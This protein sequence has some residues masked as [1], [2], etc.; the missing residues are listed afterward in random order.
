MHSITDPLFDKKMDRRDRALRQIRNALMLE[1]PYLL[2]E[3]SFVLA[4]FLTEQELLSLGFG[5]LKALPYEI[6]LE[7]AQAVLNGA[8]PPS[9]LPDFD[10]G[11]KI[12]D[13]KWWTS[14][15]SQKELKAY[16]MQAFISMPPGVRKSFSK[17]TVGKMK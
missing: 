5:V 15:A 8:G 12:E 14:W 10:E 2:A 16:A 4:K 17:W 6:A 1:D 13:A 3:S 11:N 9:S 7:C